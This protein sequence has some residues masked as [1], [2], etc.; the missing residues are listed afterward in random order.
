MYAQLGD[1]VFEALFG[2]EQYDDN[3][4]T[5]YAQIPLINRKPRLQRT[6]EKLQEINLGIGL[7][8]AFCIPEDEHRRLNEKRMNGE[9]LTFVWGSGDVEGDFVIRSIKKVLNA[10][11]PDGHAR[12]LSLQISLIEY[13]NP[14]KLGDIKKNAERNAFATTLDA[15]TPEN[16]V[17]DEPSPATSVMNDVAAADS[18][19]SHTNKKLGES[20]LKADGYDAAIDKAQAFVTSAKSNLY[21]TKK[22][23]RNSK[24]LLASIGVKMAATPNLATIASTLTAEVTAAE[25]VVDD[26]ETLVDDITNLPDPVSDLADANQVLTAMLDIVQTVSDIETANKSVKKAAQPLAVAVAG[27]AKIET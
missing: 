12:D 18:N 17:V 19:M 2:P 20:L 23:I 6:G 22:L 3:Q 8:T 15:P 26:A 21:Q 1:I 10:L 9:I 5:E 27:R 14:D 7:K 24:T 13:Y 16:L 4:E 25:I 11:S